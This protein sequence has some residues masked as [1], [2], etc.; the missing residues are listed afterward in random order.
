[1]ECENLIETTEG[2]ALSDLIALYRALEKV[3]T[4]LDGSGVDAERDGANPRS[5]I[6]KA[7][8]RDERAEIDARMAALRNEIKLAPVQ[9]RLAAIQ[10]LR[11]RLIECGDDPASVEAAVRKFTNG[12]PARA[13]KGIEHRIAEIE[14]SV[15]LIAMALYAYGEKNGRHSRLLNATDRVG[16]Q[17]AEL[18]RVLRGKPKAFD[19]AA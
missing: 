12:S 8:I 18:Q 19:S 10:V 1:M 2:V 3:R 11:F 5:E 9:S 16:E 13:D 15:A 17:L 4:S 6:E 14:G 7:L